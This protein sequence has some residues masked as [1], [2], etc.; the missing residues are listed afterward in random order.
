M[1]LR[2]CI[3]TKKWVAVSFPLLTI[4][5]LVRDVIRHVGC[6]EGESCSLG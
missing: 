1:S 3:R 2:T 6:G 4:V 5:E